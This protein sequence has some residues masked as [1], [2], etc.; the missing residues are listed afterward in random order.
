M[1]CEPEVSSQ[2]SAGAPNDRLPAS[3]TTNR[4]T[5]EQ[6]N[7]RKGGLLTFHMAAR[8]IWGKPCRKVESLV[9]VSEEN[10][11]LSH[12][13][14]KELIEVRISTNLGNLVFLS[15]GSSAW[16]ETLNGSF[17]W[18]KKKS[19]SCNQDPFCRRKREWDLILEAFK[20]SAGLQE[21]Q[22]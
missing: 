21:M 7:G 6:K 1:V 9:F 16:P 5:K 15:S 8:M 2:Q 22:T 11:S 13:R 19:A 10:A 4:V 14:G 17:Q 12:K 18:K 3:C 20:E